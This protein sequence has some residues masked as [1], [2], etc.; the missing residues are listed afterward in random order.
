MSCDSSLVVDDEQLSASLAAEFHSTTTDDELTSSDCHAH[1]INSCA[2]GAR[3]T[4]THT[5]SSDVLAVLT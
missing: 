3:D 2:A 5:D 1:S 4:L